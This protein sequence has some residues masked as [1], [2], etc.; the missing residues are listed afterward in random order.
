M[1]KF[2]RPLVGIVVLVGV[3]LIAGAV[4]Y[5]FTPGQNRS[6]SHVPPVPQQSQP[7]PPA[8]ATSTPAKI[9]WSAQQLSATL[10]PGT[11]TTTTVT[12]RSSQPLGSTTVEATPSLDEFVA[13]APTNFPQIVANHDYTLTVTLTSPPEFIKR[14][15][16]GTIHLRNSG[17]PPRTYDDP[18]TVSVRSD[19]NTVSPG[20]L[21]TLNLPL[22][23]Q[24]SEVPSSGL[25]TFRVNL[26]DGTAAGWLFVFT[27]PQWASIQQAD[28]AP[29][30]LSETGDLIFAYG[31]SE[32]LAPDEANES[33]EFKHALDGLQV[34]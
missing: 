30:F 25:H 7:N 4:V 19:W 33:L 10:F 1:H 29:T 21:F 34:P 23:W 12:F 5:P 9:T 18:V 27:R 13:V 28:V 8:A 15:F 31:D 16:G 2:V 3:G 11:R 26:P 20:N 14:S 17:T 32:A 24:I 22:G 6:S